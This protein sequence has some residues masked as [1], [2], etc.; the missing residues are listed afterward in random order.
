MQ[1]PYA[2]YRKI[3][4]GAFVVLLVASC[5]YLFAQLSHFFLLVFAGILLA[6]FFTSMSDWL[7]ARSGL[8]HGLSL[9][10]VTLVLFGSLIGLGLLVAPTVSAQAEEMQQTIPQAYEDLRNKLMHYSIGKRVL[11]QVENGEGEMLPEPDALLGHITSMFAT[12]LDALTNVGIIL[13]TGLFL[14][15]DPALYTKGFIKLFPV[16]KRNRYYEVLDKC[17]QTLKQ[18]LFGMFLAMCLIG[19]S[20]WIGFTLLGLKLALLM[21]M[22]GFFFAFIPNIGPILAGAPPI[23]LGILH[24][25]QM[26]INVI[27]VY[28]AIQMVEG[29]ILTPII[30]QKTVA[31]PPALLLF[32][33]VL[34]GIQEGG[35]GLLMAAPLL[36]V[37]LVLVQELYIKDI[38]ERKEEPGLK[39]Q[40]AINLEKD[41][42]ETAAKQ[43]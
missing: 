25:P 13:I 9:A 10:I 3:A 35:L 23:L 41:G 18:W 42:G 29:Y 31:L 33:Q 22:F 1:D 21:A 37:V 24:G 7:T 30:F 4:V 17:Y 40:R 28:T 6:V 27:I 19:V 8:R 34:L 20:L 36:A 15:S 26:A 16:A 12:T 43:A 2:N 32:F 38:L 5:F 11:E 14:A 39:E